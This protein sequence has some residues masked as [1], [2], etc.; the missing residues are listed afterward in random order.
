MLHSDEYTNGEP[1]RGRR[2]LVVGFGN[3][4]GEIAIDLCEHGAHTSLAV[5]GAVNVIPRELFGIPILAIGILQS[6]LPPRTEST[7]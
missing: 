4:G 3:S 2:V 5:R 7:L 1:F 6:R